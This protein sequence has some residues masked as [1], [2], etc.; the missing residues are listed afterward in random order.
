M[1][2]RLKN[3][4]RDFFQ[5]AD[6][7]LLGL[8]VGATLFGLVLIY[9]CTRYMDRSDALKM[10]LVQ[11]VAMGLGI[12]A[13]FILSMIDTEEL[14]RHWKWF[15]AF[16]VGFICMLLPFGKERY[17]NRAWI[18]FS[19]MPMAI[20]PT[21][22][23]KITF[24]LLLA[25]QFQKVWE[26]EHNLTTFRAAIQPTAHVLFML[27]LIFVISKD[28]GSALVYVGVFLAM[29]LAAGMAWRWF[30]VGLGGFAGVC[31]AAYK[32]DLIPSYMLERFR[33]VLDHSYDVADAG[34]QQTRGM[35][36]IGSGGLFG[37]G[38]FHGRLTQ[39]GK[40]VLPCRGG[41]GAGPCGL[42][43]HPAAGGCH[44]PPLPAGGPPGQDPLLL[45]CL[46]GRRRDAD[47]PGALKRGHVPFRP[48]G[49]RPDA[50]LF[51][52]RRLVPPGPLCRHGHRLRH[53]EAGLHRLARPPAGGPSR[54]SGFSI[55]FFGG[56]CYHWDTLVKRGQ[57]TKET[58]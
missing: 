9:S 10:L 44:H 23:V 14:I 35:L 49:H 7:V 3:T 33:V 25:W 21:E 16:N 8:C 2:N 11:T 50:A 22:I 46:R 52:L 54:P 45:L 55:A 43:P 42:R 53:Q 39:A 26:R 58:E 32:L 51:Q 57:N 17:G 30:A 12:L 41:G 28:M 37:Q 38:L 36:A 20:Q 5:Q 24:I 15:F 29:A 1:G 18:Q 19:W 34:Y 4:I 13:Y 27:G 56:I 31:L 47:L 48:A 6:L 40:G